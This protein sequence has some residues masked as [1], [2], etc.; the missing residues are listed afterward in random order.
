[1]VPGASLRPV[2]SAGSPAFVIAGLRIRG[3]LPWLAHQGRKTLALPAGGRGTERRDAKRR[4]WTK[5]HFEAVRLAMGAAFVLG[6]P[7]SVLP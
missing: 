7:I 5:E 4:G 1:M 2:L 3:A 6:W